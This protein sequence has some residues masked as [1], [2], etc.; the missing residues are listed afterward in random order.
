M[1]RRQHSADFS[2]A[3][4]ANGIYYAKAEKPKAQLY[5]ELL[6]RLTSG[7]I[8]LLDEPFLVNQ[9]AALES[10]APKRRA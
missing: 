1:R 4:E 2:R 7:E 10:G 9:L 6:P 5:A 3:F 8:E